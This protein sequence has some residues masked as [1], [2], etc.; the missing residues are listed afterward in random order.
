MNE[1][2]SSLFC[3]G[4]APAADIW[5]ASVAQ[6]PARVSEVIFS[7]RFLGR[8]MCKTSAL[9]FNAFLDRIVDGNKF[10]GGRDA[11]GEGKK[12]R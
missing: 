7:L 8:N 11:N 10:D 12:E 5:E 6:F 2:L 3:S 9:K 1:V 4:C